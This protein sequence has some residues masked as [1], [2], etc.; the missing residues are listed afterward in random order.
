[1]KKQTSK[2]LTPVT[3]ELG[4]KSPTIVDESAKPK[5]R[6]PVL[7]GKGLEIVVKHVLRQTVYC[8]CLC[9]LKSSALTLDDILGVSSSAN[10]FN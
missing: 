6:C 10:R 4:G 3:L 9:N 1:M 7:F 2:H 5:T 8:A